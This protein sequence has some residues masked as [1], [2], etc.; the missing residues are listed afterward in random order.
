MKFHMYNGLSNPEMGCNMSNFKLNYNGKSLPIDFPSDSFVLP[1]ENFVPEG[2]FVN[3]TN[4]V[5][6][7]D[8]TIE[9][10]GTEFNGPPPEDMVSLL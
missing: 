7:R 5:Q 6:C 10:P 4:I 3:P 8:F 9:F 2:S 1:G